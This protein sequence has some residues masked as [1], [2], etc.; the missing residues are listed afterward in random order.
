MGRPRGLWSAPSSRPCADLALTESRA[1]AGLTVIVD[2]LHMVRA[3][4]GC[5]G[6]SESGCLCMLQ[7]GAGAVQQKAGTGTSMGRPLV[8]WSA[9]SRRECADPA[10]DGVGKHGHAL[11][12]H[13]G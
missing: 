4:T 13:C 8:L 3:R 9:P 10:S 11:H 7:A 2:E 6:L 5:T 12:T 1:W